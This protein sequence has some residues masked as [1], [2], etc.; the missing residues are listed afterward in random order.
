MLCEVLQT[1][2]VRLAISTFFNVCFLS[3]SIMNAIGLY[4]SNWQNFVK[5]EQDREKEVWRVEGG[6]EDF[7]F[8]DSPQ[9][10]PPNSSHI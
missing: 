5:F 2:L 3:A 4:I 8:Q 10:P 9:F 1:A 7:Y 6:K